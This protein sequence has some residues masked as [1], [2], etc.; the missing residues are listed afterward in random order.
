MIRCSDGSLYSGVTTD[1]D[2][3]FKEH[4]EGKVG[5]KYTRAKLVL[6]IA[7]VEPCTSRSD[8]Q[9]REAQLKRLSK[10][11]KEDLAKN[12]TLSIR[13]SHTSKKVSTRKKD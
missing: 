8:A 2:R 9:V 11:A 1:I 3:R 10:S 6:H 13:S 12:Y 7:Y 5:A 4:K